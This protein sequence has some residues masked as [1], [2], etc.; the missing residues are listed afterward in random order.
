M[1]RIIPSSFAAALLCLA[2]SAQA[3]PESAPMGVV[4]L[5]ADASVEVPKDLMTVT[6]TTTQ[7]GE[8]A[9]AVQSALKQA[10]D[11]AL[12]QARAVA[13]PGQVDV[14]TG[15]FSLYPRSNDKGVL[16]GWRGSAELMI[17]G[18]DMP[19]ISA[20]A[21]RISSMTVNRVGY[22]L[23][24]ESHEKHEGEVAAQ[25]IARYRAKAADYV[26][27]FGYAGY[28]IREVN[29]MS[30]EPSGGVVPMMRMQKMAS[31]EAAPLPVEAGKAV[32]TVTVNGSVQM[33]R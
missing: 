8:D 25:A 30:N 27:Q 15:N 24:R 6:L 11:A 14:R 28:T 5:T 7:E 33:N 16:T 4:S 21:G 20:L 10:L 19:T 32:V 17:E 31:A 2:V 23:S 26:K 29:V 18:R 1:K 9:S 13:R 3:A 22:G 12:A